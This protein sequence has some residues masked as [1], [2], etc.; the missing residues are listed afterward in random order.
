MSEAG[1]KAK[2]HG[3]WPKICDILRHTHTNKIFLEKS[4]YLLNN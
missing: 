4:K 2:G 3:S 1:A